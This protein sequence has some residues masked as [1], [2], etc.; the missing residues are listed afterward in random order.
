V[1]VRADA[2]PAHGASVVESVDGLAIALF[3][4]GDDFC[5]IDNRC[6]HKGAPLGQGALEGTVVTC[7]WHGFTVD[8]RTGVCP[9]NPGL[10]VRTFPV[11]RAGDELRITVA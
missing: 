8:V 11:E 4:I 2:V 10:R 7:P 3:R 6:P 9:R 1:T 5:A